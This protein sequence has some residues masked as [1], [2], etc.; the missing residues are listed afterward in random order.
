MCLKGF[1][2]GAGYREDFVLNY[3]TAHQ[4]RTTPGG[5][6]VSVLNP[7]AAGNDDVIIVRQ[8]KYW[9][10]RCVKKLDGIIS[11]NNLPLINTD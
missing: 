9:R 5:G 2:H 11:R 7:D 4:R 1:P 6:G 8:V 3:P 10:W